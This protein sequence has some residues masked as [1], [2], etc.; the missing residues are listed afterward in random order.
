MRR[1][2]QLHNHPFRFLLYLEWGL[3]TVAMINALESPPLRRVRESLRTG[4]GPRGDIQGGIQ[5]GLQGPVQETLHHLPFG[6]HHS[7]I[8]GIISLVLFGLMGL[9]LPARPLPKL[10]HTLGQVL[11]VMLSSVAIFNDGRTAPFVYVVLVIR[12]C[13]MY[14]LTGRLLMTGG[15]FVL[16]V[17]G[18]LWRLRSLRDVRGFGGATAPGRPPLPGGSGRLSGILVN[19]QLNFVVLF[20]LALLLVVLLINALLTE[21]QSQ[22]RLA[23]ANQE[24]R[25]SAKEIESLAMDQERS[26]IARD[27]HDALGHSLTALNIQIESAVKLWEKD[28][29]RAQQFL[30]TAKHLGSQSL[31]DVRQSVAAL[32]QDPLAGKS[33]EAAIAD[34]LAD[35]QNNPVSSLSITSSIELKQALPAQLNVILY[36]VIQAALTNVVRHANASHAHV[37]LT[38]SPAIATLHIEDDGEGFDPELAQTGFGLQSMRDRVES[39]N[40]TFNLNSSSQGTRLQVSLPIPPTI[41]HS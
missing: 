4:P 17:S 14:G 40:G 26:R 30:I 39:A 20:G 12:S 35:I 33:L 18:L 21:R 13:L 6:W 2:I 32:R 9:Y 36:R 29:S 7:P 41:S 23:Q 27:I 38:Q 37:Q 5:E 31:K 22:Q 28:P 24:L 10:A 3:L 15:A 11:L 1:A 16:F 25:Q 8:P 19:L 34:L